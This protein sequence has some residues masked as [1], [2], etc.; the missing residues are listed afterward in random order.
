MRSTKGSGKKEEIFLSER[1]KIKNKPW[2][3]K[4]QKTAEKVL[5]FYS[6]GFK[7]WDEFSSCA[8]KGKS[9]NEAEVKCYES[10]E[11]ASWQL[12]WHIEGEEENEWKIYQTKFTD[13]FLTSEMNEDVD[14]ERGFHP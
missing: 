10:A 6:Q 14:G 2:E 1:Q 12:D 4:I 3:L 7:C 5:N 9:V 8:T 11:K 13:A